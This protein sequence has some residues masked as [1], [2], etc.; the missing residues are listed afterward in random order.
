[1]HKDWVAIGVD[2]SQT[3]LRVD[4]GM[5]ASNW[6]MQCLANILNAPVD[7]P[8]ILETTALGL[9][10]LAGHYAGVWDGI[11]GFSSSW[12]LERQFDAEMDEETRQ[13]KLQDWQDAVKRTLT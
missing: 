5:S 4:G 13:R 7:R 12:Q 8:V 9:A 1:M 11:E 3:S 10:W 6:T 2:I